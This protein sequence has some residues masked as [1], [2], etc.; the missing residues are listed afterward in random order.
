M[1]DEPLKRDSTKGTRKAKRPA[2]PAPGVFFH[3]GEWYIKASA[4]TASWRK[5]IV[6]D[7]DAFLVA[8]LRGDIPGVPGEFGYYFGGTRFL[9]RME[10][11][12]FD[13]LPLVLDAGPSADDTRIVTEMT[14]GGTY[15]LGARKVP[16]NSLHIRREIVL[17]RD[18]LYQ[19]IVVH[20]FDLE[21]IEVDVT[22]AFDADFADMFEVRGT[23]REKRGKRLEPRLSPHGLDL[24]YEGLDGRVRRT[25]IAV[26]PPAARCAGQS[27]VFHLSVGPGQDRQVLASVRP[28]LEPAEAP[29]SSSNGGDAAKPALCL[30]PPSRRP[31]RARLAHVPRLETNHDGLNRILA[32]AVRDLVTMLSET[33][34]GLYPYAG[35]PWYCAPFGRDGSITAL[36]LLPW[37]PE[38]ARGV[39]SFQARH[40]AT[41][42]DD[43]TDREPGK[44]FHELR[45]GEMAA[46]R[47]IPFVPYYGSVDAT[48][49]FVVLLAEYVHTTHDLVLLE[50]L[51]PNA[52]AALDWI[53]HHGDLDGDGFLEYRSRSPLGLRNQ[54]W[55]DSFDGIAHADGELAEPP[56]AVCEVQGYAIRA[57]RGAA[58]LALLRGDAE[59]AQTW[60]K[61]ANELQARL[62]AHFWMEDR[63]AFALALDRDKRPCRVLTTNAGH[64]LWTGAAAEEPGRRLAQRLVGPDL[65][66]GFGLR[67]LERGARRYSPLGYH[68]GTIW[69][70]DNALVAEGLRRYGNLEGFFAVFTGILN[71]V[72]RDCDAPV[73]ELFCGFQ[74]DEHPR[75][76]PYPVACAPQSWSSGAMLHFVRTLLGLSIDAR[77][78]TVSFEDPVLPDWLDW[79]EVHDL[80]V[81]GGSMDFAAVRGRTSCA[82]EVLSK[83]AGLRVLVRR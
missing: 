81:P 15:A 79:L 21:P 54:G 51:W 45:T 36:Q 38:V 50:R 73:P 57:Y 74:R 31:A 24:A 26:E 6:K 68:N 29:V 61:R 63:G 58:D 60:T 69:P 52:L 30:P 32:R 55:K 7:N 9:S 12:V 56:V 67:T 71:S 8:D 33:S 49:L 82:L 16:A 25:E 34:E 3:E 1:P 23:R 37:M 22:L 35:I 18:V 42:F 53:E 27:F 76:V 39:L 46:L 28:V 43:F 4:V 62:H 72:E 48:P 41:D 19:R 40:Q 13:D 80:T 17:E 78:S 5:Q 65:F 70:H 20:N 11:R 83:P 64:L 44:I 75:P 77:T 59:R 10:A 14:N 66:T 2:S 47:E